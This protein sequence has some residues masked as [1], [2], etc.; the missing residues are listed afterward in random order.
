[1]PG[2]FYVDPPPVPPPAPLWGCGIEQTQNGSGEHMRE[3]EKRVINEKLD[4]DEKIKKLEAFLRNQ[5]ASEGLSKVERGLMMMQLIA[6]ETYSSVLEERINGF[7][8]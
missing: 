7:A 2:V 3:H 6:M 5:E 8:S 4:L 1:M